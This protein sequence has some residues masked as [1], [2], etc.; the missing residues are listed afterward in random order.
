MVLSGERASSI[1][2]PSPLSLS[3]RDSRDAA[4]K[5]WTWRYRRHPEH[6]LPLLRRGS[7]PVALVAGEDHVGELALR[8]VGRR[9]QE[10]VE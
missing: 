10:A 4:G 6:C 9:V 3:L 1:R 7:L 5:E 8:D 2:R